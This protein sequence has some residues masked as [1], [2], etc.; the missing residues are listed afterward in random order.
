MFSM[1]KKSYIAQ[2]IDK[3]VWKVTAGS[4]IYIL[5]LDEPVAIDAGERKFRK[6]ASF[7]E[8]VIDPRYVKKVIFTHLHYDHIG[9]FDMFPQAEF[10]AGEEAIK[11]LKEDREGTILEKDM[12]QKFNAPL[13]PA[14]SLNIPQ[15]EIIK[16][17]GH[18]K[19]SICIYYRE[20]QILFSGDTVFPNKNLGRTDLPTSVPK[21]M[22]KTLSKLINY[23]FKKLCPGHDY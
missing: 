13:K 11:S 15:L 2:N 21:E 9:N 1:T 20:K 10:F 16:T 18:T 7:V 22:P 19:G 14:E 5:M 3:G 8:H 17:P 4:N 6:D 12:A 23:P